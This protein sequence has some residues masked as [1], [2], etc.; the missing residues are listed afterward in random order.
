MT[1]SN[2]KL[3]PSNRQGSYYVCYNYKRY[4]VFKCNYNK[5]I[6]EDIIDNYIKAL[7]NEL[8]KTPSFIQ[9][10]ADSFKVKVDSNTIDEEL[11]KLEAEYNLVIQNKK[12]L[13]EDI[14]NLPLNLP[15]RNKKRTEIN[16]RPYDMYDKIDLSL[17][18][19]VKCKSKKISLSNE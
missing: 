12:E 5:T 9:L 16:K 1:K 6:R 18:K 14:D 13:E 19:I 2:C 7:V 4:K 17:N 15:N 8:V 3:D 11:N 10:V